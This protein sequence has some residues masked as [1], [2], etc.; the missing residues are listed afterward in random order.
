[1]ANLV[2]SRYARIVLRIVRPMR[3]FDNLNRARDYRG[4]WPGWTLHFAGARK[5]TSSKVRE[6][7]DVSRETQAVRQRYGTDPASTHFLR[8]RRLVEAGPKS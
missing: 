3:Q 4:G 7:F 6:A 8:A 1:M 5:R 2:L